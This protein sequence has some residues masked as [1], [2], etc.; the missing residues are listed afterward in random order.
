MTSVVSRLVP[1]GPF[2]D[3]D[4][5]KIYQVSPVISRLMADTAL[6]NRDR[7][8]REE[9]TGKIRHGGS[10]PGPNAST[11]APVAYGCAGKT[12]HELEGVVA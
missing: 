6:E 7:I 11:A 10:A 12:H 8:Q 9:V 5:E 2:E 1:H 4:L 3:R